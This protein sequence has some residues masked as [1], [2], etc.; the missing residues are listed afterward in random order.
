MDHQHVLRQ[1]EFLEV[2]VIGGALFWQRGKGGKWQAI[3]CLRRPQ[4]FMILG[5]CVS[6]QCGCLTSLWFKEP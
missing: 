6:L 4:K 2:L 3:W 5:L 1:A